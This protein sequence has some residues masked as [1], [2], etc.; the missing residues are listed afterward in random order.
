[1]RR[2]LL[3]DDELAAAKLA[4][5]LA[6]SA[7]R[8]LFDARELLQRGALDRERL[9]L[10]FVVHGGANREDWRSITLTDVNTTLYFNI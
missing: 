6:R 7:S 9:R 2:S 8:D 3:L 5:L 4:A 10:G 1:V